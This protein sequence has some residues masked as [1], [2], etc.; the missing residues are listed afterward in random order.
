MERC[1]CGCGRRLFRKNDRWVANQYGRNAENLARTLSGVL[2]DVFGDLAFLDLPADEVN[3]LRAHLGVFR[4]RYRDVVHREA[5]LAAMDPHYD[6]WIIARDA[7]LAIS[8]AVEDRIIE[9]PERRRVIALTHWAA[10]RGISEDEGVAEIAAMDRN[11]L[12]ATIS[13]YEQKENDRQSKIDR[14]ELRRIVNKAAQ[15]VDT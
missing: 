9:D 11:E 4:A 14:V 7:G 13:R 6:E 15:P 1:F 5:S 3:L 10:D 12:E 8:L 2:E